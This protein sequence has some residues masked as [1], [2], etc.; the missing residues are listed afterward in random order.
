LLFWF[1]KCF[2]RYSHISPFVISTLS[3]VLCFLS[4]YDGNNLK[5]DKTYKN[6]RTKVIVLGSGKENIH[7]ASEYL[8]EN[9]SDINSSTEIVLMVGS[10][11]LVRNT[12]DAFIEQIHH[13]TS[14]C[15]SCNQ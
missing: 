8:V 14:F 5:G 3:E 12:P 2:Q 15:N 10:N 4:D 13:Q 9:S 11:D 6:N 7:G 1:Q